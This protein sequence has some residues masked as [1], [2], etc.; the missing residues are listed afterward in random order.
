MTA[1]TI[2][3]N[4]VNVGLSSFISGKIKK[5]VTECKDRRGGQR[6]K[7]VGEDVTQNSEFL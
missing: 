3:N 5:D 2:N 6:V 4:K 7:T 1:I